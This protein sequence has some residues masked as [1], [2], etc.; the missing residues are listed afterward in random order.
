VEEKSTDQNDFLL[1]LLKVGL[2]NT[3]SFCLQLDRP[4]H[5]MHAIPAFEAVVPMMMMM[6][7]HLFHTQLVH[8]ASAEM[9]L[10]AQNRCFHYCLVVLVFEMAPLWVDCSYRPSRL[11]AW[12]QRYVGKDL[13]HHCGMNWNHVKYQVAF[14]FFD[15]YQL[16]CSK[17]VRV[18]H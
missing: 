12:R 3:W 2:W 16:Q 4:V 1:M 9:I 6:A 8:L 7:C 10:V 18:Y 17:S 15:L 13:W 14:W 5:L 11:R